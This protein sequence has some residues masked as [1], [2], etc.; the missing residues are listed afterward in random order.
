MRLCA[1]ESGAGEA[2]ATG[3]APAGLPVEQLAGIFENPRPTL[4]LAARGPAAGGEPDSAGQPGRAAA[5]GGFAGTRRA[6]E[7]GEDYQTV[8]RGWCL[9]DKTFRKELLGQM[10][11]RMGVEH[12]GLERQE[13]AETQAE[14]MVVAELRRLR[15][16]GEDL[17][18]RPKEDAAKV[19]LAVRL[20]A[21]TTM[22]VRWITERLQMGS[23]GYANL[24]LYRHRKAI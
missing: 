10:K 24:L 2:L 5:V 1:A 7:P 21:E 13:T 18:R 3:R 14:A 4:A 12:Y 9:G 16:R 20:R 11:E 17:S 8:R 19:A 6:A 15:W 22:T 23:V